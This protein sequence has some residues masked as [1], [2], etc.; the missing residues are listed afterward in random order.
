M[1]TYLA[2]RH[3]QSPALLLIDNFTDFPVP[4]IGVVRQ[5]DGGIEYV[6]P[7]LV[8]FLTLF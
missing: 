5:S 8:Q 6:P 7:N 3:P 2:L 1:S 4:R